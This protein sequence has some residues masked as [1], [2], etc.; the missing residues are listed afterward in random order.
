MIWKFR[1]L[2]RIETINSWWYL[3]KNWF[4]LLKIII[5][6]INTT[7]ENFLDWLYVKNLFGSTWTW[8]W[9]K[10]SMNFLSLW[11]IFLSRTRELRFCGNLRWSDS[12]HHS[13]EFAEFKEAPNVHAINCKSVGNSHN[14]NRYRRINELKRC[15]ARK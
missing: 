10:W 14:Y 1:I 5:G 11:I 8:S 6:L 15:Y 12:F 3:S 4:F 2:D 13:K 7:I 9:R